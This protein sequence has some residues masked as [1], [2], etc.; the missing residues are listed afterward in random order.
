MISHPSNHLDNYN[1]DSDFNHFQQM[2]TIETS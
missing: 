2:T 1:N